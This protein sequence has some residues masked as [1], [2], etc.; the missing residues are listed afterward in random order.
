MSR[1]IKKLLFFIVFLFFTTSGWG[2]EKCPGGDSPPTPALKAD[3]SQLLSSLEKLKNTRGRKVWQTTDVSRQA[4]HEIFESVPT[5]TKLEQFYQLLFLLQ[6]MVPEERLP[7]TVHPPGITAVLLAA[8]VFKTPAFPKSI[9]EVK[10]EPSDSGPVWKVEF[11]NSEVRFPLNDGNGFATWDQGMCQTAKELVFYPGFS[12][13]IRKARV[14]KNLIVDDF[15]KVEIF[16]T[17][18]SHGLFKIDLS[19]VD[20]QKVEF[21]RGTDKGKVTAKVAKRE[22]RTNRHS[23]IFKFIGSL[24]PNTAKQRIDW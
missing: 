8:K 3:L 21:I 12:F 16:G 23:A 18:G 13:Q 6:Q 5:K 11:S 14:S 9:T 4:L 24:I 1:I 10:V 2:D 17:F 22:F 7:A 15:D 20:L 19:Y